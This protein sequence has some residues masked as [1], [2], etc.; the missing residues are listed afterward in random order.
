[1]VWRVERLFPPILFRSYSPV[2]GILV[3]K[4]APFRP[5]FTLAPRGPMVVENPDLLR[6]IVTPGKSVTLLRNRM[7]NRLD[8]LGYKNKK[9]SSEN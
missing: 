5:K 8:G 4:K 2:P 6:L 1:M 7:V 9:P 3:F